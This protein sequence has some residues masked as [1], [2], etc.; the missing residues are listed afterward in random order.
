[1][2]QKASERLGGV[3]VQLPHLDKALFPGDGISK[4]ELPL[5]QVKN[6]IHNKLQNDRMRELMDKLNNSFKSETNEAY[7]GPPTASVPPA[8]MP[9]PPRPGMAPPQT[10]PPGQPPAAKQD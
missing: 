4:A 9:R 1:M 7:F 3:S 6:E 2:A 5:D 8:H 10:P